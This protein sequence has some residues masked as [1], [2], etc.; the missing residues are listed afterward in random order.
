[1]HHLWSRFIN[2][3]HTSF[4]VWYLELYII[5]Y[6]FFLCIKGGQKNRIWYIIKLYLRISCMA[7]SGHNLT[8]KV[9]YESSFTDTRK[10]TRQGWPPQLFP[11]EVKNMNTFLP[12]FT[13][14][15][16]IHI[17]TSDYL[18]VIPTSYNICIG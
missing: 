6:W 3:D 14:I 18:I 11:L 10:K 7:V 4:E 1:M 17:Y 5:L 9:P 12:S 13:K 8:E 15:C 2:Q 16:Q